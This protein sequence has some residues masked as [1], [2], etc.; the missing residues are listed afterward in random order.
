MV[1]STRE[2]WHDIVSRSEDAGADGLELTF[3]CPHGMSESAKLDAL[4]EMIEEMVDDGRRIDEQIDFVGQ[5]A[6]ARD[7][8]GPAGAGIAVHAHE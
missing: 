8:R 7:Q 4:L 1:E 3:G 5:R 2:A 6:L